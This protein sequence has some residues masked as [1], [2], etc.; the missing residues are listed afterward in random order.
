[1]TLLYCIW[2]SSLLQKSVKIFGENLKQKQGYASQNILLIRMNCT[3][4][5]KYYFAELEFFKALDESIKI[6]SQLRS[7]RLCNQLEL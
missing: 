7:L 3:P 2:R 6:S 4:M 5:S 1:M